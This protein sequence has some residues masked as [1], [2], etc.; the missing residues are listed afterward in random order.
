MYERILVP[1]D[2]SPCSNAGLAE[3]M[4]LAKLTGAQLRLLHVVDQMP[5]AMSAEGYSA[6]SGDVLSLLREA[7]EEILQQGREQAVAAG[8]ATDTVMFDSLAGRVADRVAE[9]ASQWPADLVVLG[10]HGR[11]GVRRMLLGSDAEQVLRTAPVPVL[12]VRTPETA[13]AAAAQVDVDDLAD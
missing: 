4:K 12:L 1:V 13:A 11:R 7:G 8:I 10:T 3:A 6:I 2:G 9:Q 5:F